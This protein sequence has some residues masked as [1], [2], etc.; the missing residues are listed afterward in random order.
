[1]IF[2]ISAKPVTSITYNYD[3]LSHNVSSSASVT[4]DTLSPAVYMEHRL[5]NSIRY[6]VFC[7]K[8]L[9]VP[10]SMIAVGVSGIYWDSFKK[11]NRK[12]QKIM[13]VSDESH[14]QWDDFIQYIPA[15]AYL[16]LGFY[17]GKRKLDFKERIAVEVTAYLAMTAIVNI[18]KYSFREKRPDSNERNSFPS[19]HTATAFT[20]AELIRQEFGWGIGS[21]AY[22]ISTGVAM[23]RLY[24]NRHWFNDVIAGA[25]VGILSA[26]IGYW[27]HP[28]YRKL[29]HWDK[30]ENVP[31]ITAMPVVCAEVNMLGIN[32]LCRF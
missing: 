12:V 14:T 23:L 24:N 16:G 25:G 7:P 2:T 8:Q 31:F 3:T 18:G 32:L 28:I 13:A 15:A 1:M 27:M 10:L 20:G 26:H 21:A 6:P 22:A 17:K 29:F 19:G 9:I 11:L 30:K 4:Y 5:D